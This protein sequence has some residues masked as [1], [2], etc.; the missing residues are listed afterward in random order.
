MR[1]IK[2]FFM[3]KM[4]QSQMK[5][6]PK[7]QQEQLLHMVEKDPELF[8][9]IAREIKEEMKGG[10]DQMAAAMV[11]LPKYQDKLKHLM[12]SGKT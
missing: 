8:T 10:K 4:L 9:K 6:L 3:K 7:D 1:M 2:N 12:G 11:V 5:D